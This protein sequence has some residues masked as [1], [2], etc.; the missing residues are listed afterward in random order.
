MGG[1]NAACSLL[2]GLCYD[3]KTK[4]KKL[5]EPDSSTK[6]MGLRVGRLESKN[7]FHVIYHRSIPVLGTFP[8][9]SW[10][11]FHPSPL[12]SVRQEADICWL[13][14]GLPG[15]LAFSWF[16]PMENT[17]RRQRVKAK[18]LFLPLLPAGGPGLAEILSCAS[19]PISQPSPWSCRPVPYCSSLAP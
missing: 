14:Q 17:R 12:T 18:C 19:A 11:L 5:P 16:G 2:H 8:C 13:H 15:P 4:T 9:D 1:K 6:P 10:H 3:S 7:C